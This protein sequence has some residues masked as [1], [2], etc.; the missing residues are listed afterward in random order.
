M[1]MPIGATSRASDKARTARRV[2]LENRLGFDIF[3]GL[4][5]DAKPHIGVELDV[6][7]DGDR[8]ARRL[9]FHG[10][11]ARDGDQ[12]HECRKP[13]VEYA[14]QNFASRRPSVTGAAELTPGAAGW[15][16]H[17]RPAALRSSP[18]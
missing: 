12:Q 1:A 11:R 7:V 5:L 14:G 3:L 17:H 2:G 18:S 13:D 15:I 9:D 6:Q 4:L 8:L 10:R 16:E